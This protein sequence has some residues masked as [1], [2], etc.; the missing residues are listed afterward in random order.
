[1]KITNVQARVLRYNYAPETG[2]RAANQTLKYREII[3]VEVGSDS[4][5]IG[6]GE[7]ITIGGPP[8]STLTVIREE[9]APRLIGHNPFDRERIW[10]ELYYGSF[11]HARKGLAVIALSALDVAV[12][13]LCARILNLPLFKLIGGYRDKVPAYASA[14]FYDDGKGLQELSKEMEGYIR[15]GFKA[16]KMKVGDLTLHEDIERVRAVRQ[17]VGPEVLIMVDA[18]RAYDHWQAVRMGRELEKLDVRFFEEPLPADDLD[19]YRKLGSQLDVPLAAGENEYTLFGFRDLID[20]G[21]ISIAQPD[22]SWSG[23]VTACL[24]I[25]AMCEARHIQIAPHS[26]TSIINLAATLHFLGSIPNGAWLEFDQNPNGLRTDLCKYPLELDEEGCI[27]IPNE[28]G[29]GVTLDSEVVE[30]YQLQL[31]EIP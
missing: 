8:S 24:K 15:L 10:H 1:M 9:M 5:H 29:I 17:A 26:F 25:A 11:Q 2:I 16:V 12:W 19:G 4:G 30:K 27:R 7:A 31:E 3:L 20:T 28:P 21:G 22:L 23:G 13:D 18:N 6:L 14:G